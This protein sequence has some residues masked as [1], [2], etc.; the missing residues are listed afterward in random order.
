MRK[1]Q[2]Q[3]ST[4]KFQYYTARYLTL[5]YSKGYENFFLRVQ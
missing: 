2:L 1:V 4:T 5:Y 3:F